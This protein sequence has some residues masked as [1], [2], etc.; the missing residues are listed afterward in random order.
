MLDEHPVKMLMNDVSA[1]CPHFRLGGVTTL[2]DVLEHWKA[3]PQGPGEATGARW[4][5]A[6]RRRAQHLLDPAGQERILAREVCVEGRTADIRTFEDL[7]DG[8]R[9]IALLV[10]QRDDRLVQSPPGSAYPRILRM[11]ACHEYLLA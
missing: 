1:L 6:R 3:E 2:S 8:D 9:G 5:H 7:L 10:N 4:Q 11:T